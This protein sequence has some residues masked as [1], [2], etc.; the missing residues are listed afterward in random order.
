MRDGVSEET[1]SAIIE[2]YL[3]ESGKEVTVEEVMN[4]FNG[5]F[6]ADEIESLLEKMEQRG[7]EKGRGVVLVCRKG[8]WALEARGRIDLFNRLDFQKDK[9]M[10]NDESDWSEGEKTVLAII[11]HEG[12]VKLDRIEEIMDCECQHWVVSLRERGLVKKK[13]GNFEVSYS[14]Y[15]RLGLRDRKDIINQESEKEECI[16]HYAFYEGFSVIE[17]ANTCPIF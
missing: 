7:W 9:N 4:L 6:S 11:A 15:G 13:G 3:F 2:A 10:A 16:D 5:V 14:F 1:L 8:L 17:E 12:P